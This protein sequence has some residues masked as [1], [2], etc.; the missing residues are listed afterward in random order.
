MLSVVAKHTH[1][2][3]GTSSSAADAMRRAR[4]IVITMAAIN[5]T[6][7]MTPG[8]GAS[9]PKNTAVQTRLRAICTAHATVG[10]GSSVARHV[11][12]PARAIST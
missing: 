9:R 4:T 6:M 11:S 3:Y 5:A 8:H 7:T 2:R 10:R 1:N 12:Q